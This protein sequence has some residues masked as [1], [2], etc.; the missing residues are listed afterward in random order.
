M[1]REAQ[2][3]KKGKGVF[4]KI[5]AGCMAFICAC[6][7]VVVGYTTNWFQGDSTYDANHN[8]QLSFGSFF[9]HG[10]SIATASAET[11]D[12]TSAGKTTLTALVTPAEYAPYVA[13]DWSIAWQDP[14]AE[15]SSGKTVTDYVT[16][17]PTADG[18]LTAEVN[19]K[20]AFG[21]KIV[22][23]VTMRGNA[24][25]MASC[26]CDY[27][28]RFDEITVSLFGREF[29]LPKGSGSTMTY[30]RFD[31]EMGDFACDDQSFKFVEG[32]GVGTVRDTNYEFTYSYDLN[33]VFRS[34]LKSNGLEVSSQ[35]YYSTKTVPIVGDGI[36]SHALW[37]PGWDLLETT[38]RSNITKGLRFANGMN[39]STD[40]LTQE[41]VDDYNA[42]RNAV[43]QAKNTGEKYEY[44][45]I[46][47]I[48]VKDLSINIT[49][50][51]SAKIYMSTVEYLPNVVDAVAMEQS[52][53]LF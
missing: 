15:F 46:L 44:L 5:V 19:C 29:T 43:E 36:N 39:T 22:I 49:R 8:E 10:L 53:I 1:K 51:Y 26:V 42:Y 14:E 7:A 20:Q 2:N 41:C 33:S 28:V 13:V 50:S 34:N 31:L 4:K 23:T 9:G 16:L 17:T 11:V 35:A 40:V 3:V 48:S 12:A 21:E 47:T 30:G 24:E 38:D 6:V 27:R 45:A 37:L 25:L 52:S 18:A 32:R